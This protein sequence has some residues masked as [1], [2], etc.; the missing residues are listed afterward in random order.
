PKKTGGKTATA[1]A[2]L[3]TRS[4]RQLRLAHDLGERRERLGAAGFSDLAQPVE[5]AQRVRD[6]EA[7][8][9]G[10]RIRDELEP[11]VR[12]AHG[13]AADDAVALEVAWGQRPAS[14]PHRCADRAPEV[15]SIEA[16]RPLRGN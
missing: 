16:L 14:S 11:P 9:R 4:A 7:P 8:G 1:Q 13:S 5:H 15:A 6:Q 12:R 2:A 10:R 3:E